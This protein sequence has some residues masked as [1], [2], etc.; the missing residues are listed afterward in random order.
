MRKRK[1]SKVNEIV[2]YVA[3]NIKSGRY[4]AGS[5]MPSLRQFASI[6]KISKSTAVM[7][8]ERLI[9]LELLEARG[10][11][12]FFVCKYRKMLDEQV[13]SNAVSIQKLSKRERIPTVR[14]HPGGGWIDADILPLDGLRAAMREASRA[15]ASDL[16]HYNDCQGYRPLRDLLVKRLSKLN[17]ETSIDNVLVTDSASMGLDL[18]CR[19]LLKPGDAVLVDDP[20]SLDYR[21]MQRNYGVTVYGVSL[22]NGVR[23]L[24]HLQALIHRHEPKLYVL[25]PIL[26]NPTGTI[27]QTAHAFQLLS[28]LKSSRIIV[29]EDDVF[30]DIVP[31]ATTRL[32]ELSNLRGVAYVG[33]FSKT[34]SAGLRCGF[35]A[36]ETEIMKKISDLALDTTFGLNSLTSI[37][38]HKLLQCG[39]YRRS[40]NMLNAEILRLRHEAIAGL[41]ALGFELPVEN[42]GGIFI[43]ACWPGKA[44][45]SEISQ[46]AIT[47]QMQ[48]AIGSSFSVTGS[49]SNHICFNCTLMKDDKLWKL[50]REIMSEAE[51][52]ADLARC[53]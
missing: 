9:A 48:L 39:S 3:E 37:I 6:N 41:T 42:A 1:T 10:Q 17:I 8:F 15:R 38:V 30:A 24:E 51:E 32:S 12:G 11:K 14:F 20:T 49:Y 22:K 53:D 2:D 52:K 28:I 18:L 16:M 27:I 43:W 23:D 7:I 35:I 46:I 34:V 25:A 50:L 40:L 45:A 33:S 5:K 21:A 36:A 4:P 13:L 47:R 29:I 31:E 44:T 26:H 19:A